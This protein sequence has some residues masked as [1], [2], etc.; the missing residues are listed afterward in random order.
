MHLFLK[1]ERGRWKLEYIAN[2]NVTKVL[3]TLVSTWS[4]YDAILNSAYNSS[5]LNMYAYMIL[6]YK[7]MLQ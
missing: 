7:F 2:S 3:A 1:E 4:S 6:P 5:I